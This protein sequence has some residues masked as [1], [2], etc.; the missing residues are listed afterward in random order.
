MDYSPQIQVHSWDGIPVEHD[1]SVQ[2]YYPSSTN[3][4]P[5]SNSTPCG[6][7]PPQSPSYPDSMS[8][9]KQKSDGGLRKSFL[10]KIK[11]R[12]PKSDDGTRTRMSAFQPPGPQ[13]AMS[14]GKLVWSSENQIWMFPR[15]EED[16]DVSSDS[17]SL[18]SNH[19]R[20]R[21]KFGTGNLFPDPAA[22]KRTSNQSEYGD[23]LFAQVPGHYQLGSYGSLNCDSPP[24]YERSGHSNDVARRTGTESQW[25]LVAKR[26]HDSCSDGPIT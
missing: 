1:Q 26:V 6:F 8:M 13:W 19:H 9:K 18:A 22:M 11:R 5:L 21:N 2:S 4:R 7:L 10:S 20:Q 12:R 14:G 25:T 15:G 16:S 23:L 24:T 17:S 3:Q